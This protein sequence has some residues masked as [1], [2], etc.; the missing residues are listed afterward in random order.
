M[1]EELGVDISVVESRASG[2]MRIGEEQKRASV[3]VIFQ[4]Q[5]VS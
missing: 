1:A 4:T 2:T 3:S 5:D